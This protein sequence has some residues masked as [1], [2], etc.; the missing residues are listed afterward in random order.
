MTLL[1]ILLLVCGRMP[2]FDSFCIAFGTAGT[3]GF[4]VSSAGI[5][6]YNSAYIEIVVGIFML[7]FG[8]NFNVYHLLL[9][10]KIKDV[11]KSEE[12]KVYFGI[13]LFATIAITVNTFDRLTGIGTTIRNAFF[14]VSS[15]MTTS[16]FATVDFDAW[17]EFSKHTLVLLMI[18]GACAGS[19][20][21]GFKVS[22]V[23]ILLKAFLAE[24]RHIITPKAVITV[25]VDGKP[26]D[27]ETL[28]STKIYAAV[29]L[30]LACMFTWI[31]SLDGN[32]MTT[33]LTAVLACFNNIGPGLALVG[34]M[35]NYS[36]YSDWAQVLLSIAMLTG[37]LEIFPMFL[38]FARST[39]DK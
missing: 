32:D 15:I 13:V 26:V 19:T 28:N 34:P 31:I 1:L 29:Y 30:I 39:H 22:R 38:L 6:G 10:K 33:N 27:K 36:V 20:G 12:V 3:G 7:L 37:R 11:V 24:I 4:A 21:G 35:A 17:P 8:V 16:G 9:L 5:A 23:I 18:I 2:V 14:Q 25:R